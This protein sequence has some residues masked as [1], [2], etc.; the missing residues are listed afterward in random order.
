MASAACTVQHTAMAFSA[1]LRLRVAVS[2]AVFASCLSLAPPVS[3]QSDAR[4][5]GRAV[6][7]LGA[8][9]RNAVLRLVGDP[10]SHTSAHSWRYVLLANSA[11]KP[12]QFGSGSLPGAALYR[13]QSRERLEHRFVAAE[14]YH[15]AR[16]E[17][18]FQRIEARTGQA[19]FT[20]DAK[21]RDARELQ[22]VRSDEVTRSPMPVW[23]SLG[24]L[25]PDWLR[26]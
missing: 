2:A 20:A 25:L 12:G 3:A 18:A 10:S 7:A 13:R 14:R 9:I 19:I 26:W 5:G 11:R 1:A 17:A 23:S 16:S 4:V 22:D 6:D 15:A 24:S 21:L 8:P